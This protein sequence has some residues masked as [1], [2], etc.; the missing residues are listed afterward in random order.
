MKRGESHWI[1][2]S[3]PFVGRIL[4]IVRGAKD[5]ARLFQRVLDFACCEQCS[6]CRILVAG[7]SSESLLIMGIEDDAVLRSYT[8][9]PHA[10]SGTCGNIPRLYETSLPVYAHSRSAYGGHVLSVCDD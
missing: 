4:D 8:P 3:G 1:I 9:S 10:P 6:C 5:F 2:W 7:M